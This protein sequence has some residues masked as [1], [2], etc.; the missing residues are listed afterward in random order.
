LLNISA[1]TLRTWGKE[2]AAR[3][4]GELEDFCQALA[5]TPG[6]G[7]PC[8]AIRPGLR[9]IEHGSHVVFYRKQRGGV[10]I[11]RILHERMLPEMHSIDN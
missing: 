3:Y 2:Q 10:L 8:D 5:D 4:V 6:L 7:R 9:R 11:S 1:Y